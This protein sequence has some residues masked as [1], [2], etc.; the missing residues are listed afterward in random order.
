MYLIRRE[1]VDKWLDKN[2][3]NG[4]AKLSLESGLSTHTI[5]KIRLGYA[6]KKEGLRLRLAKAIGVSVEDL[7]IKDEQAS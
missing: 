5:S 1:I 6:L 7:F 3:P 4:L 2:A